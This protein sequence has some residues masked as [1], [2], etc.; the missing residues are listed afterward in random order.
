MAAPARLKGDIARSGSIPGKHQ[1]PLQPSGTTSEA[2]RGWD[3]S[4]R[5]VGGRTELASL[6]ATELASLEAVRTCAQTLNLEY[7]R[8]VLVK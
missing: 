8:N 4:S 1:G 2:L 6:E 7:L 3:P 5:G